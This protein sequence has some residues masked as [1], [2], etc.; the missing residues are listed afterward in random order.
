M[1]AYIYTKPDLGFSISFLSQ[2]SSDLTV[3]YFSIVKQVYKYLQN[4]KDNKLIYLDGH[5]N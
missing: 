1:W 3:E 4:T 5:Q 2:F